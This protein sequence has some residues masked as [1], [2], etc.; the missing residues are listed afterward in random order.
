MPAKIGERLG[1]ARPE[2]ARV[3]VQG[4]LRDHER[5]RRVET[6]ETVDGGRH[7]VL[8]IRVV[9][10]VSDYGH[11]AQSGCVRLELLPPAREEHDVR[12]LLRKRLGT[13]E[14]EPGRGAADERGAPAQSEIHVATLSAAPELSAI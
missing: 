4:P 1:G 11:A 14:P 3:V 10:H 12:A 5:S 6:A 2:A 9:G 8:E 13:R 7:G